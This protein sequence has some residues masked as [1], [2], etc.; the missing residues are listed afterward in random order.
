MLGHGLMADRAQQVGIFLVAPAGPYLHLEQRSDVDLLVQ[1]HLDALWDAAYQRYLVFPEARPCPLVFVKGA[2]HSL[3]E[4]QRQIPLREEYLQLALLKQLCTAHGAHGGDRGTYRA[5]EGR[6]AR[7]GEKDDPNRVE[8]L[9][10]IVRGDRVGSW[11]KLRQRPV[12]RCNVGFADVV[13]VDL[14]AIQPAS[15]AVVLEEH[16]DSI[17][18]AS[19]EVIHRQHHGKVPDDTKCHERV[20]RKQAVG[21][22]HDLPFQ[23]AYS[24][25]PHQPNEPDRAEEATRAEK[26]VHVGSPYDL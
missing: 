11:H 18:A 13:L 24:E 17:P 6:E 23:L 3:K 1:I 19:D 5:D 22:D 9:P 15:P 4:L 14:G 8:P 16:P 20:R 26:R 21:D 10:R 25:K 12:E 2:L 7:H